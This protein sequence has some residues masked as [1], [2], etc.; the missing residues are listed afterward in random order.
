[1]EKKKEDLEE[2]K[3]NQTFEKD[4]DDEFAADVDEGQYKMEL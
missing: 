2:F 4:V 1:M 3:T